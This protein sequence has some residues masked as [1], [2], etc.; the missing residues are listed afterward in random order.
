M[1][2][3]SLVRILKKIIPG[4][5]YHF[6]QPLYHFCLACIGAVIYRFPSRQIKIVAITGTKGKSSTTEIVNAILEK[7]GYKTAVLGTIRFKIGDESQ[8]NLFKMTMPGRF[9]THKFLRD[10]VNEGCEWAVIEMTSQ[11]VLQSRHRFINLDAFIFTNLAPEHIESHGSFENYRAAKIEI[12]KRLRHKPEKI[13]VVNGDDEASPYFTEAVP[14]ATVYTYSLKQAEPYKIHPNVSMRFDTATIY[15]HLAGTFNISNILASATFAKAIGIS[16][17]TIKQA[18]ENIEVIPGRAQKIPVAVSNG[19]NKRSFD[20]YVD[21]AHTIESLQAFYG[22]F[23]KE[24]HKICIL[25]N[26]GGGRD[27]CKRPKMAE[28]ADQHCDHIIL[29]NEDPYD[30]DPEKIL[31]EMEPGIHSTPYDIIL[32]R[33]TAIATALSQAPHNSLVLITG[34]GTDPYIMGPNDTKEPWS[35]FDVVHEE[36]EKLQ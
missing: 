13:M 31:A 10:A 9:F 7:A 30:E 6:F 32:D 23:P 1:N 5:V 14:D 25:G 16:T 12:A 28:V 26:T 22:A 15:T 35:D 34:K 2:V 19:K 24:A 29:T 36:A 20:V 27:A 11:A 18:V 4:A 33:R 3:E 21:Y 17:E 8:P